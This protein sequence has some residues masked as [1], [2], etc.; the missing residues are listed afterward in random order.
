LK[1]CHE[2]ESFFQQVPELTLRSSLKS[3]SLRLWDED[4]GKL[5]GYK[6]LREKAI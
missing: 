2:A 5:V 4:T 6:I 1:A 3:M